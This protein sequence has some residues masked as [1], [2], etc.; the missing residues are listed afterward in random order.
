LKVQLIN[1]VPTPVFIEGFSW[2]NNVPEPLCWVDVPIT[3]D[4]VFYKATMLGG[5]PYAP[6]ELHDV[7]GGIT[8]CDTSMP[9]VT[10]QVVIFHCRGSDLLDYHAASSQIVGIEDSLMAQSL[11]NAKVGDDFYIAISPAVSDLINFNYNLGSLQTNPQICFRTVGTTDF[12]VPDGV[13]SIQA[14]LFGGGGGGGVGETGAL[15]VYYPKGGGGGGGAGFQT[16]P[17]TI[18]ISSSTVLNITVGGGGIGGATG[19]GGKGGSSMISIG[20]DVLASAG[21]GNGGQCGGVNT[22]LQP[23]GG[24]GGNGYYGGGGGGGAVMSGSMFVGGIG[25]MG[26]TSQDNGND[27]NTVFGGNGGPLSTSGTGLGGKGGVR[28]SGVPSPASLGSFGGGGGGGFE[29]GV[30]GTGA[31]TGAAMSAN[32]GYGGDATGFCGSGGGGGG[33]GLGLDLDAPGFGGNGA[34][35]QVIIK[36]KYGT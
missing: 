18:P 11:Q 15:G 30:G 27:G 10:H 32:A 14:I 20:T 22:S 35:G 25:G 28:A 34:Q 9:L 13:S 23:R 33:A 2:Q 31:W 12:M 8:H 24:D 19:S 6:T 17:V 21:G 4:F 26:I 16:G 7:N 36:L 29:G 3:G 5:L 1:G